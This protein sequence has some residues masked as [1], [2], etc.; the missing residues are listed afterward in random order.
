MKQIAFSRG[1]TL[2]ENAL[3]K[4]QPGPLPAPHKLGNAQIELFPPRKYGPE[5]ARLL[6]EW[7]RSSFKKYA[8]ELQK[9]L[10]SASQGNAAAMLDLLGSDPAP[11][12]IHYN[13]NLLSA[14]SDGLFSG[15]DKTSVPPEIYKIRKLTKAVLLLGKLH[16]FA[17]SGDIDGYLRYHEENIVDI[18]KKSAAA[19]MLSRDISYMAAVEIAK[20]AEHDAECA[21][22]LKEGPGKI[23]RKEETNVHLQEEQ[24]ERF[25]GMLLWKIADCALLLHKSAA[26]AAISNMCNAKSYFEFKTL[27]KEPFKKLAQRAKLMGDANAAVC[28]ENARKMFGKMD[29]GLLH[30]LHIAAEELRGIS[31][32]NLARKIYY[33][34]RLLICLEDRDTAGFADYW[35]RLEAKARKNEAGEETGLV[36][37]TIGDRHLKRMASQ[38]KQAMDDAERKPGFR[39][40][41]IESLGTM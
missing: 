30:E 7:T 3:W 22:P 4:K 14:L 36:A 16:E 15:L 27:E 38:I 9:I 39:L 20:A 24:R 26:A 25:M 40:H 33:L 12:A 19:R 37:M 10:K 28:E 2:S 17:S 18:G 32:G 1:S 11:S 5:T 35:G 8:G 21:M 13:G 31:E 23:R 6:D 29:R 34:D 41:L